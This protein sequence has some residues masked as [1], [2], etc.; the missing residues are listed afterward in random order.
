MP[1]TATTKKCKP[2]VLNRPELLAS[3]NYTVYEAA[4][5]VG[6]AAITIW[7]ALDSQNLK[8][9]RVGRRVIIGGQHL[10]DW[11][12]CGGRTGRVKKGGQ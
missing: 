9:F 8:C 2:R 4:A 11:L 3:K 7:R 12:E 10:L 1:S 5:A 6:C